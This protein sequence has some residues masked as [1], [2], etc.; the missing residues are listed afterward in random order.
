MDIFICYSQPKGN[1][2]LKSIWF[3]E[4][5]FDWHLVGLNGTDHR[6]WKPSL[7]LFQHLFDIMVFP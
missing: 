2:Q 7:P 4:K 3:Y 5:G 1:V 6:S